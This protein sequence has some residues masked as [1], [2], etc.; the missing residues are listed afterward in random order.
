[1]NIQLQTSQVNAGMNPF[2]PKMNPMLKRSSISS[3]CSRSSNS[4]DSDSLL[5][6]WSVARQSHNG[7][8]NS[9][10]IQQLNA[11]DTTLGN[12][13]TAAQDATGASS[14]QLSRTNTAFSGRKSFKDELDIVYH[15]SPSSASRLPAWSCLFDNDD[16]NNNDIN[17]DEILMITLENDECEGDL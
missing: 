15:G 3:S 6:R 12:S 7:R 16:H 17:L 8:S 2:Q 5:G 4:T 14:H 9:H 1:M 13:Q 11:I 10:R